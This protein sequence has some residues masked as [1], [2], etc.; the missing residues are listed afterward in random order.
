MK[1]QI[2][3]EYP[4]YEEEGTKFIVTLNFIK[5][6]IIYNYLKYKCISIITVINCYIMQFISLVLISLLLI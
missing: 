6:T 2:H 3:G 1:N 4:E 5:L